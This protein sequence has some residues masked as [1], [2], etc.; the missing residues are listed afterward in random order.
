MGRTVKSQRDEHKLETPWAILNGKEILFQTKHKYKPEIAVSICVGNKQQED[1]LTGSRSFC[2]SYQDI[3]LYRCLLGTMSE[4]EYKD[5]V[6]HTN[7]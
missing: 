2:F 5:E 6:C 7:D 3:G 1:N 4:Q